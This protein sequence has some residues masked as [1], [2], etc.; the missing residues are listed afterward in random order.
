MTIKHGFKIFIWWHWHDSR[1]FYR[2]NCLGMRNDI[3]MC[4]NISFHR[5]LFQNSFRLINNCIFFDSIVMLDHNAASTAKC[6]EAVT[7]SSSLNWFINEKTY[8]KIVSSARV[9]LGKS[10]Q[11]PSCFRSSLWMHQ[12]YGFIIL[13]IKIEIQGHLSNH[14]L[15]FESQKS[16]GITNI[17]IRKTTQVC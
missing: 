13:I 4:W 9:Y 6:S 1:V 3:Q 8:Q 10:V 16:F 15:S 17:R 12:N 7:C 14:Y 11:F 5:F 2:K